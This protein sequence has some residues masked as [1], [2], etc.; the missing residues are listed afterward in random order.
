MKQ[1][2]VSQKTPLYPSPVHKQTGP[3][4]LAMMIARAQSLVDKFD[5]VLGAFLLEGGGGGVR[6]GVRD[7]AGDILEVDN[8][9]LSRIDLKVVG[10][11]LRFCDSAECE[12][13]ATKK[14]KYRSFFTRDDQTKLALNDLISELYLK[15]AS[16][17]N[18]NIMDLCEFMDPS[19]IKVLRY[20]HANFNR[21]PNIYVDG[22]ESINEILIYDNDLK[23]EVDNV[24]NDIRINCETTHETKYSIMF[25]LSTTERTNSMN[26]LVKFIRDRTSIDKMLNNLVQEMNSNLCALKESFFV[27]QDGVNRLQKE[28]LLW[29]DRNY[30][31]PCKALNELS[32]DNMV[33]ILQCLPYENVQDLFAMGL[34]VIIRRSNRYFTFKNNAD[35]MIHFSRPQS[36]SDENGRIT[37]FKVSYDRM[38]TYLQS[39]LEII[40]SS[41]I[42]NTP[43]IT[44][45]KVYD[46]LV[47]L[48]ETKSRD[49]M[50]YV[51]NF[52]S[53]NSK[54]CDAVFWG[55]FAAILRNMAEINASGKTSILIH[56]IFLRKKLAIPMIRNTAERIETISFTSSVLHSFDFENFR[57]STWL[58]VA[59]ML[60]VELLRYIL[61]VI[62]QPFAAGND[63]I[64]NFT[65]G[66]INIDESEIMRIFNLQLASGGD[67][68]TI[69][70]TAHG[71]SE[72]LSNNIK[73]KKEKYFDE[74]EEIKITEG[75]RVLDKEFAARKKND[76]NGKQLVN[77]SL[78]VERA[79][80]IARRTKASIDAE[81]Q[82]TRLDLSRQH[83]AAKNRRAQDARNSALGSADHADAMRHKYFQESV[84]MSGK[85]RQR[86]ISPDH[87][88]G[89][90]RPRSAKDRERST[91]AWGVGGEPEGGSQQARSATDEKRPKDAWKI[92]R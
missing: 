7:V 16:Q 60:R 61:N 84:S 35:E 78:E 48:F 22:V 40:C 59:P 77:E 72:D 79:E 57:E 26:K 11:F 49:L 46:V 9:S 21:E 73:R 42:F 63:K 85:S 32:A 67:N 86:S 44:T 2:I 71:I 55:G 27:P 25:T 37:Q 70:S 54:L 75:L 6:L 74:L 92:R 29:I 80:R 33:A 52:H 34:A 69:S 66:P 82:R 24:I 10:D 4:G 90:Q 81:R 30:T 83:Q 19:V 50:G 1:R 76:D 14:T 65:K 12:T 17:L 41:G 8:N 89:S 68:F 28:G 88:R 5:R 56:D 87:G 51:R 3:R 15:I 45:Q 18:V 31:Y 39:H 20:I 47:L 53:I 23:L 13:N 58:A 64:A 91:D 62:L 38:K 36:T 43:S